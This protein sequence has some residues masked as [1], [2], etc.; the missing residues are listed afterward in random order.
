M[1]RQSDTQMDL[2]EHPSSPLVG[3][4]VWGSLQGSLCFA[5]E[6]IMTNLFTPNFDCSAGNNRLVESSSPCITPKAEQPSDLTSRKVCKLWKTKR[7]AQ[8]KELLDMRQQGNL[9]GSDQE[10]QSET[11]QNA[12]QIQ[13]SF[14]KQFD[15]TDYTQRYEKY[16]SRADF[17]R[18]RNL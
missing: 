3:K 5:V 12:Q 14:E 6:D 1:V 2:R 9:F 10:L 18:D 17:I 11:K 4:Q 8:K 13:R 15:E 16:G 7:R